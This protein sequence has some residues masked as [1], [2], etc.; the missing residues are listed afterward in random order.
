M[1]NM[2]N[3]LSST[4]DFA[5]EPQV[6][7]FLNSLPQTFLEA[8]KLLSS[9]QKVV[10]Y[11]ILQNRVKLEPLVRKFHSE[12][13]TL[14]DNIKNQRTLLTDPTTKLLVSTHQPNLF[15]YGGV[16]KKIVLLETLKTTVEKNSHARI[17]NLF[18]VIDHDFI[19]EIWMRRAQVPS[20]HH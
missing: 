9:D 4:V 3:S 2:R 8:Q 20:F 17:I 6:T 10:D 19:D 1:K 13:G 18:V 5:N 11:D 16:F 14:Y 12:A 7:N 15:A